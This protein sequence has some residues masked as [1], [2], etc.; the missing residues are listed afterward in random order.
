ML[1]ACEEFHKKGR[2]TI[3]EKIDNS[4]KVF[5]TKISIY[6]FGKFN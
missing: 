3:L 6:N 2:K 1:K 4:V 5:C